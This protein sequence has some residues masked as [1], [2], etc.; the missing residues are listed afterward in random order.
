MKVQITV[1][2]IAIVALSCGKDDVTPTADMSDATIADMGA[3][4]S[5]NPQADMGQADVGAPDVAQPDTASPDLGA[6][7]MATQDT[8]SMPDTGSDV[9]AGAGCAPGY[10]GHEEVAGAV[11]A[12]EGA[13]DSLNQCDAAAA[14]G[15]GWHM[16]TA[17]EYRA[18]FEAVE[19]AAVADATY[20][21][22]SCIREGGAPTAPSDTACTDCTGTQVGGSVEVSFSC[23]NAISLETDQLVVGLRA[24]SACTF[25]GVDAAGNDAF[26]NAQPASTLQAGAF[27]C[28]D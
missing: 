14:C 25:A 13:A 12:C 16:C 27:C 6:P 11:V 17:T 1:T 9:G 18:N 23:I 10:T 3:Q 21:I 4:D 20:W 2:L 24:G 15:P 28:I 5:N 8:G 22:A 26:W 7:D 19:P